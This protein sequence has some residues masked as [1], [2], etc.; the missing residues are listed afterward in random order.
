MTAQR[1]RGFGVF[2]NLLSRRRAREA[3]RLLQT[4]PSR[5]RI[6]DIGCGQY[7]AFLR[8]VSFQ[9]KFGV[10]KLPPIINNDNNITYCQHDVVRNTILP[11]PKDFFN[12]ITLLAVIE[13]IDIYSARALLHEI[14][15]ILKPQ[16]VAVITTPAVGTGNILNILAHTRLLSNIEIKEHVHEYGSMELQLMLVDARFPKDGIV[17]GRFECRLNQWVRAI[18]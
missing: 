18:K 3:R 16:G 7:G 15:R 11:F 5:H 4:A 6:L 12:A 8:S 2:E 1:T 9:E 17:Y 13:H 14:Y 10:D